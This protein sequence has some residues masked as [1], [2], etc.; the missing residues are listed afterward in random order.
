MENTNYAVCFMDILGYQELVDNTN[1]NEEIEKIMKC[2]EAA[3]SRI[4]AARNITGNE[5]L[6]KAFKDIFNRIMFRVFSDTII[7]S[8]PLLRV[9]TNDTSIYKDQET[10]SALEAFAFLFMISRF[11]LVIASKTKY[12]LRGGVSIG[13]YYEKELTPS[14]PENLFVFSKALIEAYQLEK[15]AIFPRVLISDTF[16]KHLNDISNGELPEFMKDFIFIDKTGL[17]CLDFYKADKLTIEKLTTEIVEGIKYQIGNH[18]TNPDIMN[19][20]VYFI[21][22]HNKRMD[23]YLKKPEFKIDLNKM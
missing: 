9:T 13:D 10:K 20:Y 18:R 12:Y 4:E 23:E 21:E 17:R 5:P 8:M 11:Y 6:S 16:Y 22:Y 19:K 3:F 1:S 2:F 14:Q 7:V 15:K